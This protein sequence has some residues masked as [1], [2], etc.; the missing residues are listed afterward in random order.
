MDISETAPRYDDLI[1][2]QTLAKLFGENWEHF[3]VDAPMFASGSGST[4]MGNVS[5]VVPSIHPK[6][7]VGAG[8]AGIHTREFAAIAN[9]PE[10]YEK[11]LE[12][13]KVMAH[14]CIDVLTTDGLLEKIKKG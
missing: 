2:N 3:G 10:A 1:T 7:Q 12:V 5:H 4:D 11:T 13:G 8:K 9:T 14:T 6:F